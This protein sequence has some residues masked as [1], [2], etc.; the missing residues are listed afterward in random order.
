M[1][2]VF[3]SP[4][5]F[6]AAVLSS[7]TVLDHPLV[8]HHVAVVRDKMTRPAEFRASIA[9]L[10]VLLGVE[11]TREITT[12]P[13]D[14][15]TPVAPAV[16]RRVAG[17]VALVPVLRAGLGM[18]EPI[19]ALLPTAAVWHLGVYRNEE[20]AEPVHYYDK[21]P[22]SD[23]PAVALILDPML[24]TGGSIG[25][26][27]DRLRSWG[28]RDIRVLSV[29]ASRV[30]V[31]KVLETFE[32]AQLFVAAVDEELND[33]NYIVPGLGDAGDRIFDTA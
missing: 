6:G 1:I 20:T 19:Q 16:G 24:A 12:E 33:Q 13:F 32:E 21:L 29:I 9:Q 7:L 31:T 5:N 10:S 17:S 26:V 18:V 15:V 3:L 28:V 23:A 11:A 4:F 22:G 14:I 27:I 30:G 2:V 25:L 8:H